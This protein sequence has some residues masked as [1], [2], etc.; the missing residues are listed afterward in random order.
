MGKLR[1]PRQIK[2]DDAQDTARNSANLAKDPQDFQ[3]LDSSDLQALAPDAPLGGMLKRFEGKPVPQELHA[4]NAYTQDGFYQMMN[5]VLKKRADK[6][7]METD[8]GKKW[9]ADVP[10]QLKQLISL[11]VSAVRKMKPYTGTVYRGDN[12]VRG[13]TDVLRKNKKKRRR[14]KVWESK[15]P[16]SKTYNQFVSTSKRPHSSYAVRPGKYTAIHITNIKTGVDVSPLGGK[17][18]EREVL[19]APGTRFKVTKVED[20]FDTTGHQPDSRYGSLGDEAP[21]N[22]GQEPGRIKVTLEE[23]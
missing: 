18:E 1:H 23:E 7:F 11:A 12:M 6:E 20:R 13:V 16:K 2:K 8:E 10:D 5:R 21:L 15:V 14:Q 9:W 3:N 19:F 22:D 17:L 4:L